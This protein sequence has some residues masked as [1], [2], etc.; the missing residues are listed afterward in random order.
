MKS[1]LSPESKLTYEIDE[2]VLVSKDKE[3]S[4]VT[5]LFK[6]DY[7]SS[8]NGNGR[9]LLKSFVESI[10]NE[11]ENIGMILFIDKGVKLLSGDHPLNSLTG[12]LI[13][14]SNAAYA[15]DTSIDYYKV[16]NILNVSTVDPSTI[17]SFLL[18]SARVVVIE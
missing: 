10:L 15:D 18:S 9:L 1:N 8:D 13:Q 3:Q 2:E 7:Y 6:H 5:I 16:T 12:E 17:Y 4:G 11:S 14:L